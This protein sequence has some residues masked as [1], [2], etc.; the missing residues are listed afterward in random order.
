MSKQD[1]KHGRWILP[2]VVLA[3]VAFTFTFV[4]SLPPAEAPTTTAPQAGEGTTTTEPPEET[5]TTTL[6]PGIVEF[7][8]TADAL[9]AR[10]DELSDEAQ[11]INDDYDDAGYGAT[12]DAL[13]NLKAETADFVAEVEAVEEPPA[14]AD[15]WSDVTTAAVA[16]QAG[17]DK[18]LDGLVNTS[19]SERRLEGLEDYNIAAATLTQAIDAAKDAATGS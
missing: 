18:M 12:R 10:A 3:L 8:A 16:M 17:A 2:L 5:T 15:R 6:A 19:G 7:V 4:N 14:A 9:S 1:P 11:I 13:S